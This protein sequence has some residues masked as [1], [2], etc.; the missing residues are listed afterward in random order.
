[1]AR[2][3]FTPN[4]RT[5]TKR[6]FVD[7]I[8]IITPDVYKEEDRT[9]SGVEINPLSNILNTHLEI[10][11]NIGSV[12]SISGVLFTQLSALNI[13][14]GISPYFVKQN[15]LTNIDP[16]LFETKILI[17]LGTSLANFNT[18]AE[19]NNY[20]SSTFLPLTTLA[21]ESSPGKIQENIGI[22]SAFTPN[23]P[24]ASSVHNYLVD[25]LGWFYFLNTSA[26]G[27]LAW[28]PSGYVLSSLN[29]L[30]LGNS[31]KTVDGIKGLQNYI[32]RNYSTCT[33]FS[34]LNL[35]PDTY[36]SGALDAVT[37]SASGVL[38]IYT[39][40]TQKLEN[41]LTLVDVI[42]S[43]AF[44]DQQDFTVRDAFDD[45][46]E[47]SIKLEDYTAKGP[48]RKFL[49]A[50]GFSLADVTN[51]VEN[52]G[53]I[54][55][56]EN[57]EADY[58]PYVADLLG[59]KLYGS[60]HAKWRRQLRTAVQL[61][62][63][64]GT[65]DSIQFVLDS[66]VENSV[67]DVSGRAQELWE[68]YIPFLI[69]Y[70]LGTESPYFRDLTTWTQ[71]R[72]VDASI[73]TYNTSS[74]EENIKIVTDSIIL[75]LYK[76][77]PNN[78][79]FNGEK[80]PVSK[81][82]TLNRFGD[83]D[84]IYTIINE[85]GMKQ[86]HVHYK[87]TEGYDLAQAQAIAMG[88]T[89]E[90]NA[91]HSTGPLGTGVY[92]AGLDHPPVMSDTVYLS[93]TG[94]LEFFFSYRDYNNHPLPPFEEIKYYKDCSLTPQL[95]AYLKERLKC[96]GVTNSHA[97][98][99]ENFILSAGINTDTNLGSLNEFLMFFSATQDPPNYNNVLANISDYQSNY[100]GLWN[101]KSSHLLLEFT[102]TNFDFAKTTIE[103]D[104]KYAL[105]DAARITK[106]FTP[107]HAI[108]LI[109]LNASTVDSYN[110]SST[111]WS[112]LGLDKDDTTVGYTSGSVLAGFSYSGVDMGATT[113]GTT[114]GRGGLNTFKRGDV[115]DIASDKLLYIA[116]T[117]V[118]DSSSVARRAIR[119]RN[120]KFT[121]PTEGYYERT[122]FNHP[123]S[124]DASTL[125][126]SVYPASSLGELPLGYLASAGA[127]YPII[128][129]LNPS[130]V[131]HQC[132][133][134]TSPR[135]FSGVY[136]SA[137]FPY[138][139]LRELGSNALMSE[140]SVSTARYVDRGQI[141]SIYIV[142]HQLYEAQARDLALQASASFDLDPSSVAWK[143]NVQSYANSAIASGY[144]LN[145]IDDYRN[146][147]FGPGLH[148]LYKDYNRYPKYPL[149][150]ASVDET[151]GNLFA[152]IFG[153][154]LYNC[155]FDIAGSAAN[156]VG[157]VEGEPMGSI[158]YIASGFGEG[159]PINQNNGS[160]IFSTCA[161]AGWENGETLTGASGTYI[162][163]STG[164]MV[165]PLSGTE[166]V[167]GNINNAEFRNPNILSGIEF[168][169]T[170]GS[171]GG[172][173]FN[174][175][176]VNKA[177]ALEGS[178]NY[179][180]DNT[181]IKCKTFG[182]APR[183]RFDLS[184]YGKKYTR[185]DRRNYFIKDH[186]FKLKIKAL[187]GE[188]GSPLLGGGA[189]GVWLHTQPASGL[190][191]TW[192]PAGKWM[193]HS[194]T[195]TSRATVFGSYAH[196][197]NF[198]N[199]QIDDVS[200]ERVCFG[201]TITE[202]NTINN[203]HLENVRE[204]YFETHELNFDT[205]NYTIYNNYEYLNIIPVP[206]QYY[207]LKEQLHR[208]D[209][210]YYVE[211]FFLKPTDPRKY[212]LLDNISLEDTTQRERAGIG[213]GHGVETSGIPLRRFVKE[214]KL[215]LDKKQLRTILKFF[216]GLTGAGVGVYDTKLASRD[217]AITA[218]ILEVSGGSRLNYRINPRV[219]PSGVD[220]YVRNATFKNYQLIRTD[221]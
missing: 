217:A 47:A 171:P 49:N 112:Y 153:K 183:L 155:D 134:L 135:A 127:F 35:I 44:M 176:K 62:K 119:R 99:V 185:D 187:V 208:D 168:C 57:A 145:S 180:I 15:N 205:R 46:I 111:R 165:I 120:Y 161:V 220:G 20:L 92:M 102:D 122:G 194:S 69:W 82:F 34:N 81:L 2:N 67:L 181:I 88:R 37:D 143:D 51:Q 113:P 158:G 9:L 10:G 61:Y 121:L 151:G 28:E 209:T 21:T 50:F 160:G 93:A 76:K 175:F 30:Y 147:K 95:A 162:A 4:P 192:N 41:L 104:S 174:I 166:F 140:Y 53:L 39:S 197:F 204:E 77:F 48:L 33:T 199:K 126:N 202:Q 169:D 196:I 100:L 17:P 118:T 60:S 101:G 216:D 5:Y 55:D 141:P 136:T 86:F 211:V 164:E 110:A 43:P 163:S 186:T 89:L 7:T 221:N 148:K 32:W 190:M 52:I 139:G 59:W 179:L 201:N 117:W 189:I 219:N 125:E 149:S 63:R 142:M 27:G 3:K 130:G 73:Y 129:P 172:N 116:A 79:I 206:E 195:E 14:S 72:A 114:D 159:E 108:P 19:F 56:I 16:Y 80:F 198:A 133:T 65:L 103:G 24:L 98:N 70:S 6:N 36:V 71:G 45:F 131:W 94:D 12:L 188:D 54:Y 107:A 193:L 109:N 123:N 29:K 154:G 31:L 68:S 191:W 23:A 150:L 13:L 138:R 40:G 87:G 157:P 152:H 26:D 214:D 146:F 218:P 66:L 105:Y 83:P 210:N 25:A 11:N 213:T 64:K 18:S 42:Y 124:W 144:V 1:M 215:Y 128:D 156:T 203:L 97:Q 91:A 84:S 184:S 22:L 38:P 207:K 170:S 85:P 75:D 74:L 106:R 78:F 173:S 132:E 200:T 178:E 96:F 8:E 90:W 115:D 137:T 182:G 212:L 177:Y 58:L 167:E